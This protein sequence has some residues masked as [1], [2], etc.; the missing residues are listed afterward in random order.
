[1][2]ITADWEKIADDAG[3]TIKN[4]CEDSVPA[5]LIAKDSFF[6]DIEMDEEKQT[7]LNSSEDDLD[8]DSTVASSSKSRKIKD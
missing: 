3:H 8:Y 4:N 6:S 1:M 2:T 7:L 5:K